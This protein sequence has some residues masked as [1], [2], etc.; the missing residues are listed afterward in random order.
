ME[1]SEAE[2][3]HIP[4]NVS[5]LIKI[6]E[7][8]GNPNKGNAIYL[9]VRSSHLAFIGREFYLKS[10][11]SPPSIHPKLSSQLSGNLSFVSTLV[12]KKSLPGHTGCV[13]AISWNNTGSLLCT[14]SDDCKIVLFHPIQI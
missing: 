2:V 12:L 14:G 5:N 6:R 11:H 13:N 10:D 9:T 8:T 3:P 1:I 7:T 4:T